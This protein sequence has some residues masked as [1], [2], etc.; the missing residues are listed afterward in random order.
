MKTQS[1]ALGR[2]L[3]AERLAALAGSLKTLKD[4]RNTENGCYSDASKRLWL[5][6]TCQSVRR[7][8][9]RQIIGFVT[10]AQFAYHAGGYIGVGYAVLAALRHLDAATDKQPFILVRETSSL[11]YRFARLEVI[12]ES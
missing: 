6:D 10:A 12:S 7:S 1:T 11:Q 4:I 9:S 8:S 5:R 2:P 3:D